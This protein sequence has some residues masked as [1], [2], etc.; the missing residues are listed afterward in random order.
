MSKIAK[1]APTAGDLYRLAE[2]DQKKFAAIE[3]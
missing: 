1:R 2:S 3:S